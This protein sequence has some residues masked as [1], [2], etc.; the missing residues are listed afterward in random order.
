MDRIK[1]INQR[2]AEI[3]SE[4]LNAD[5]ATIERLNTELD[6]LLAERAQIQSTAQARQQLRNRIASGTE[7]G[8]RA[9]AAPTTPE[10]VEQ[11]EER[12]FASFLRG[13]L[14]QMRDGEQDFSLA[15]NGALVPTTIAKRIIDTVKDV[16]PILANADIY[17]T[18]GTLKIPVYGNANTTHNIAVGYVAE[19]S[20]VTPD[21]GA[22]S[23]LELGGYLIRAL[24]LVGRQLINNS[25]FDIVSFVV[26][27]IAEDIS[28]FA[29][30]ELLAGTGDTYSHC[31][32][33]LS[34]TNTLLAGSTSDITADNLIELQG[35]VKQVYQAKACWIMN[36]A[37]FTLLRKLKYAD[38]TYI[39]N[40]D[41]TGEFP[42]RILGKPVY[43]SDNMPTITSAAKA[44]L[45]GDLT[46]LS[47]N[48]RE[49]IT[50]EI[51][52]EKFVEK[53]AIGVYAFMEMDSKVTNP[54]KLATLVMSV[55]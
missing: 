35:K 50:V 31:T 46:G 51:A 49:N 6:T 45:Y 43:L 44:V 30:G 10:T 21:A 37:T 33:A 34:T 53:H 14:T 27:K 23:S 17:Y 19:F 12:A 25:E 42:Y 29:E 48:I 2:I 13:T 39:V 24:S 38:G 52:R 54:Q 41:F 28:V 11:R 9:T 3:N 22:F 32:G 5:D 7:P 8:T 26:R 20:D 40:P 16:C 15:N 1:E 55:A 36:P 47:V 18:K 4:A